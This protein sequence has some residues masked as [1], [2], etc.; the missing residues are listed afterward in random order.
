MST[1][2]TAFVTGASGFVGG[3]LTE[4][5]VRE[6]WNV[7]ALARSDA[8][9]EKVK[10]LGAEPV[11]GDLDDLEAL[12]EGSKRADV[13]FH[14]AAKV[15]EWGRRE[16][17]MHINV[18]GTRNVIEAARRGGA[19]RLVHTGTEAALVH[20]QPL[21]NVDET[22]PLAPDSPY[23]YG[24]TKAMAEQDVR[25]AA[26]PA[27]HT[28]VI[29]PRFVWGRGDTTL[30]PAFAEAVRT[31]RFMW[32][33]DGRHLTS[34]CHVDNVVE[35]L[36]AGARHGRS[37]EAYFV[38]DGPP[39]EFRTFLEQM[40]D[41]IGVKLP[42]RKIPPQVA[43]AVALVGEKIARRRNS[44]TPPPLTRGALW[45]LSVECTVD[46]TKARKELG[47]EPPVTREAGLAEMREANAAT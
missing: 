1:E 31:K 4:R 27:L 44:P 12:V 37:G 21:V 41:T 6:G 26:G 38:T 47:Y 45:L 39:V 19:G 36:L 2:Q 8:S 28:V 9:A 43:Q 13:V 20:G 25:A 33:G 30:L 29:R 15:E 16:D 46:D 7:K 23:D 24:A 40:M 35:G 10:A 14:N 42:D 22:Y 17:F 11:R 5:L 32:I 3:R 18:Q 34:T